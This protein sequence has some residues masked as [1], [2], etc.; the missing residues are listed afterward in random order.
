MP[1]DARFQPQGTPRPGITG[2]ESRDAKAK[3]VFA[4]LGFLVV[5]GLAIHFIVAGLLS[6]FK[7]EPIVSDAWRLRLKTSS[8]PPAYPQLQISPPLDLQSFRAREEAE[9]TQYGWINRTAGVVRI[10]ID[11][12]MDLVLQTGFPVRSATNAGEKGPSSYQLIQQRSPERHQ[13]V[14][15]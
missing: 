11:R 3:W 12:A 1:T 2:H 7:G 13:G 10:P 14:E 15:K 9:L 6:R 4:A 8:T 5:A